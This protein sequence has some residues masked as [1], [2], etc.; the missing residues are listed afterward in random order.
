MS[1]QE[2]TPV[3]AAAVRAPSI[4]N[5]Q[6]WRFVGRPDRL[7]LHLDRE[8]ALPVVDRTAR[9]QV[10]SCGA[11]LEFA[12]VALRAGGSTTGVEPVP[13]PA[14]PDLLAVLSVTG[15]REA[16]EEDRALLAAIDRRHTVR[17]V[18]EPR[19]VPADLVD[20]WA[21]EAAGYGVWVK[22]IDR[23]D[24]EVA[25]AVLLGRAE[26]ME[27]GDEGYLAELQRWVRTGPDAVDGVPLDAVPQGD[28]ADRPS[29]WL[30]RD[31]VAGDRGPR[32]FSPPQ[33]PDAPPPAVERPTVLLL[34]TEN[35]D[36]VAW[37][38]AGR[39]LGRLLLRSTD[40][41]V[42]ASPLTQA[43]D[44]PATRTQLRSRLS[45][46]GHP[47]MLLR[48]GY[49]PVTAGPTSGRRPIREVLT[50]EPG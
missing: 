19:P 43:L 20:R 7:E 17:S 15:G 33:D 26:E 5:T 12:V 21:D 22:P 32:T 45:L 6:P 13:D 28:P 31:F 4:H 10:I 42:V 37:L 44:W 29:N 11:A 40:A 48:L 41:G 2:W 8:R 47:Q 18:F 3:V 25:T 35:D 50:V 38:Q 36:R 14:N 24:E 49:A 34:G 30:V 27:Q 1:P 46:V 23:E 9:Q 39:A 16:T